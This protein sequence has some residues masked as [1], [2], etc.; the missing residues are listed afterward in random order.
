MPDQ[1][2]QDRLQR[3]AQNKPT[4][5]AQTERAPSANSGGPNLS[6]MVVAVIVI[7]I[8]AGLARFANENYE[9]LKADGGMGLALGIGLGAIAT[10]ICG[11]VLFWRSVRRRPE[12]V[13]H[14]PR[15]QQTSGA[16]QRRSSLIGFFLGVI[17]CVSLFMADAARIV[18]P[19]TGNIFSSLALLTVLALTFLAMLIGI[20]GRF[21]R[22]RSL[23][24]VPL[25]FLAGGILTYAAFRLLRINLLDSPGFVA[26]VQ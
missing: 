5:P 18:N 3:I 17:A 8:G 7:F 11:M 19:D 20:V 6:K 4:G 26:L 16:A 25:Y 13:S 1:D 10:L 14:T 2:F 15:P 21:L 23:H 24:R 22:G 9:E 12:Q